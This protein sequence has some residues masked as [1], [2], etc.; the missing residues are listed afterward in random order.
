MVQVSWLRSKQFVATDSGKHSVVVSSSA[1]GIGMSP[2]ELLLVSLGSCTGYDIA[3]IMLKKRKDL[4]TLD[5]KVDGTE[6]DEMPG[7]YTDMHVHYEVEGADISPDELEK[8]IRGSKEKYCS[9]SATLA[10]SVNIT[11]SYSL[12]GAE[13]VTVAFET[14][15]TTS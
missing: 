11:Y 3:N 5:V 13:R 14:T 8:A 12:N 9:V 6:H 15:P 7:K 10:G 2:R 1:D 4:R